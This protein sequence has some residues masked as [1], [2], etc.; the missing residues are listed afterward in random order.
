MRFDINKIRDEF[1]ILKRKVNGYPFVYLDNAATSQK[2]KAV[3]DSIVN[4]YSNYNSNI[5]R[6]IPKKEAKALL[7]FAFANNVL[8]S[9]NIPSV[10]SRIKK[11]IANKLG[12]DLGFD[13]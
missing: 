4:Y 9:V 10:K 8:E 2:P 5:H 1:P 6:G 11:I 13:L 12:V 7:T 3:I